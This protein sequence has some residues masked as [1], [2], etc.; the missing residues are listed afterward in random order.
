MSGLYT[1]FSGLKNQNQVLL[2]E[3]PMVNVGDDLYPQALIE[4]I[5][6]TRESKL[7][8]AVV[9]DAD[10]N[11]T[12]A[13]FWG[14]TSATMEPDPAHPGFLRK[15]KGADLSDVRNFMGD[16]PGF[17]ALKDTRGVADQQI[18]L[19]YERMN[20]IHAGGNPV[21]V[22]ALRTGEFQGRDIM[23][24]GK[25][26]KGFHD[27]LADE[28]AARPDLFPKKMRIRR[29]VTLDSDSHARHMAKIG[30]G[31][32]W[33]FEALMPRPSNYLS[34]S[35]MFRQSY[36]AEGER[37]LPYMD[38]T[39]RVKFL[40]DAH[41]ARIG[42][43]A[44]TRL[45][46]KHARLTQLGRNETT[47]A[48][49]PLLD[50][51]H[52]DQ[53]A[54]SHALKETKDLLYDLSEKSQFMDAARLIFPFGEAWR[55]IITRWSKLLWE[56]PQVFRRGTQ[57]IM[58]ARGAESD[59]INNALGGTDIGRPFFHKNQFGEEIVG[60]PGSELITKAL[61]GSPIPLTGS[62][63]GLNL[64]GSGLPGVGPVLQLPLAY[65][66]PDKPS[67]D[68]F[69]NI[70]QPFGDRTSGNPLVDIP[71]ALVPGWVDKLATGLFKN[72]DSTRQYANAVFDAARYLQSTG[73]YDLQG[74][75]AA[76]EINR[77]LTDAKAQAKKLYMVRGIGQLFGPT[78]PTPE[79]LT[80]DKKGRMTLAWVASDQY[81]KDV[82][83]LGYE[84]AYD[85]FL[86]RF[87]LNNFLLIQPKSKALIPAPP[88]TVDAGKWLRNNPDLA[89]DY[90]H[91][92]GLFA[93][94]THPDKFD[95]ATYERQFERGERQQLTAG[96]MI[97]AANARLAQTAY[98]NIR[99]QFPDS[100]TDEQEE[101][102]RGV[103]A[104]ITRDFPGYQ[105]AAPDYGR[106]DRLVREL[107]DASDDPRIAK[108]DGGKALR[109]YLAKRDEAI[110]SAKAGGFA[111]PFKAQGTQPL[112]EWLNEWGEYYVDQHPGFQPMW[113]L[114][115]SN[116]LGDVGT[117]TPEAPA[118]QQTGRQIQTATRSSSLKG[119][120]PKGAQYST[121][122]AGPHKSPSAKQRVI[123]E[124]GEHDPTYDP[125]TGLVS[126]GG[127]FK[128]Y[129][130]GRDGKQVKTEIA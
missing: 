110:A 51:D 24:N 108:T 35:P 37:L 16:N 61:V 71:A 5:A 9:Q 105:D 94:T 109:K 23:A 75:D 93:P 55:E 79:W 45:E 18:D 59:A 32:D 62:V 43:D 70:I 87:G 91:V 117:P 42:D 102:L 129:F 116:E 120:A 65:L 30:Q 84:A 12:K 85:K 19:L 80:H 41:T 72:P 97:R 1:R 78:P 130:I 58:G 44:I 100:L 107:T 52:M 25:I 10:P 22:D 48:I 125:R 17:E 20:A 118:Q 127:Q 39:S 113:D 13:R 77:L 36:F 126:L 63:Q 34:R 6:R 54:K 27:F 92:Y 33:L 121:T 69:A 106:T 31:V 40:E 60:L 47:D 83:K 15:K 68:W 8:R 11:V 29:V 67:W 53:L 111:S 98:N 76:K 66:M 64:V 123:L 82:D 28:I 2:R 96:E 104:D 112:R 122:E 119:A 49:K 3:F 90:P 57:V 103:R 56:K 86:D 115:F 73:D 14:D 81:Q 128:G 4:E 114:V 95:Q 26:D 46:A 101:Y 99:D 21:L 74:A 7:G 38:E 50:Y 124:L 88:Q 89:A